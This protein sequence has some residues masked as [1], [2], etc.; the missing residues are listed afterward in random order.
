[1]RIARALNPKPC[2]DGSPTYRR[3]PLSAFAVTTVLGIAALGASM[4][5][6]AAVGAAPQAGAQV[7]PEPS[8][9]RAQL[10]SPVVT[11]RVRAVAHARTSSEL[12]REREATGIVADDRGHILTSSFVVQEHEAIVVTTADGR[13][14]DAETVV[15]D[16]ALGIAILRP[17]APLGVPPIALGTAAALRPDD[18]ALIVSAARGREI[19]V[20]NVVARREFAANWEFLVERAIFTEPPNYA[21]AGAA[22]VDGGGRLVGIGSLLIGAAPIAVGNVFIPIDEFKPA[23]ADLVRGNRPARRPWLGLVSVQQGEHLVVTDIRPGSPADRAGVLPG[24]L[25]TA[26]DGHPVSSLAALYRRIWL[27]G[28]PGA[29]LRLTVVRGAQAREIL[30]RSIDSQDYQVHRAERNDSPLRAGGA[31]SPV[32]S[33]LRRSAHSLPADPRPREARARSWACSRL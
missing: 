18:A 8:A 32:P 33:A 23:L 9:S 26:V 27:A 4:V 14:V 20:V 30:V 31:I 5:L 10:L 29:E 12:G 3:S 2:P 15:Q 17:A 19:A 22:L 11:I 6:A 28:T 21:W 24:D 1:M 16:D 13:T 25:I 7:T